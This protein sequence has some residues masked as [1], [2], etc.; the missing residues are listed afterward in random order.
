MSDAALTGRKI[1]IDICGVLARHGGGAF[2]GKDA[3]KVDR[4]AAYA[5]RWVAEKL[6]HDQSRLLP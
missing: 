6:V 5:M 4:S 3:S 1:I 2:P